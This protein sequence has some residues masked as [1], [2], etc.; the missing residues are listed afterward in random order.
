MFFRS[1]QSVTGVSAFVA[2]FLFP[3]AFFFIAGGFLLLW[4]YG[5]MRD[6]GLSHGEIIRQAD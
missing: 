2:A 5:M 3:A 4:L 1:L 6:A